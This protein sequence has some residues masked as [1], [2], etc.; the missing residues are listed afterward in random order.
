LEIERSEEIRREIE[1]LWVRDVLG[2]ERNQDREAME[3]LMKT[4]VR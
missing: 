2:N 4:V 3:E 1:G